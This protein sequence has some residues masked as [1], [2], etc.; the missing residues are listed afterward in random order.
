MRLFPGETLKTGED[1]LPRGGFTLYPG[2]LAVC[3]G[4]WRRDERPLSCRI[5]PFFP[6]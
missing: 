4:R 6:I 1:G 3:S 2:D 5:F